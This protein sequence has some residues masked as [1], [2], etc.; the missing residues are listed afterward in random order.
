M[1]VLL[2]YC[3]TAVLSCFMSSRAAGVGPGL[4]RLPQ[5][6]V[7]ARGRR[8][9]CGMGAQHALRVQVRTRPGPWAACGALPR[10]ML[11][12]GVLL[13]LHVLPRITFF[14]NNQHL[15]VH[16]HL[17]LACTSDLLIKCHLDGRLCLLRTAANNKLV[18][19]PC[20]HEAYP[21]LML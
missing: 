12:L 3:L 2:L 6:A 10:G 5:V 1:Q 9:G 15:L 19:S 13:P 14:A 16:T 18:E 17:A 11:A 20:L 4:R 8:H 21:G 7:C